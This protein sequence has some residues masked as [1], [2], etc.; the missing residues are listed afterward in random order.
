MIASTYAGHKLSPQ[1]SSHCII[2]GF[3]DEESKSKQSGRNGRA[4]NIT[5]VTRTLKCSL[6]FS[7]VR[8]PLGTPIAPETIFVS[9][10]QAAVQTDIKALRTAPHWP[11]RTRIHAPSGLLSCLDGLPSTSVRPNYYLCL[12]YGSKW[13]APLSLSEEKRQPSATALGDWAHFCQ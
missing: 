6:P 8:T 13:V 10:L 7:N 4:N 9:I 5:R 12:L 1:A 3:R 11:T 2:E